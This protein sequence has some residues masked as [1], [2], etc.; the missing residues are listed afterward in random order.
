MEIADII[1]SIALA[2]KQLASLVNRAGISNLTG[3]AGPTN[4]S[5]DKQKTLDL[6]AND[7]F[8]NC[9]SSRYE[10]HLVGRGG[11]AC[12][13]MC[14]ERGHGV[15]GTGGEKR[16]GVAGLEGNT[17]ESRNCSRLEHF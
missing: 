14:G 2:C 5:G 4:K 11:W 7:V 9:L 10:R 8:S 13:C 3:L 12:G 6:V 1:S 16:N 17:A 15:A